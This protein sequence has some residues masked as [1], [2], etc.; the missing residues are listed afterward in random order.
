MIPLKTDSDCE[1]IIHM[2]KKYGMEYTLNNL[3]GVFAFCLID[4]ENNTSYL[5]RDP[6]GGQTYVPSQVFHIHLS[7]DLTLYFMDLHRN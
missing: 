2:F 4:L 7:L 5:A 1:I 6:Y 3:D